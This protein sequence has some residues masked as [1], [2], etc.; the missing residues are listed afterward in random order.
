MYRGQIVYHDP[1]GG[2]DQ[3]IPGGRWVDHRSPEDIEA[4]AKVI[5]DIVV[6]CYKAAECITQEVLLPGVAWYYSSVTSIF[7]RFLK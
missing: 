6:G 1:V 3:R 5:T 2:H 4:Q 7:N